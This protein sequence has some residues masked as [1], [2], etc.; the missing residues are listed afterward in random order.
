MSALQLNLGYGDSVIFIATLLGFVTEEKGHNVWHLN[1]MLK[2]YGMSEDPVRLNGEAGNVMII[3]YK[4]CDVFSL[5]LTA[6]RLKAGCE[7]TVEF[8]D[9]RNSFMNKRREWQRVLN[10]VKWGR[11]YTC[12]DLG[13]MEFSSDQVMGMVHELSALK[14]SYDEWKYF[15]EL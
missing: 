13:G 2:Y 3:A 4:L 10:P 1:E 14:Q 8:K 7:L 6:K 9:L 11:K 15:S 12:P 5:C